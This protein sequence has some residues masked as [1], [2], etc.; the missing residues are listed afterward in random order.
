MTSRIPNLLTKCFLALEQEY[1]RWNHIFRNF[2]K[3]LRYSSTPS[4]GHNNYFH[5]AFSYFPRTAFTASKTRFLLMM[6]ATRATNR[7]VYFSHSNLLI[8]VITTPETTTPTEIARS[9]LTSYNCVP[10]KISVQTFL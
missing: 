8:N 9:P 7:I 4:S 2:G 6:S 10:F 5:F 3:Q 1:L